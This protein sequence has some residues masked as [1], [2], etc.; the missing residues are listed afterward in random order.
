MPLHILLILVIGGIAAI[1]VLMHVLG[2]SERLI[3][4]TASARAAWLRH[5]PE[6]HVND[7]V[8]ANDGHAALILAQDGPGLLWSFGADTAA[9]PLQGFTFRDGERTQTV[10][11]RDFAAPRV[12][13]HLSEEERREWQSM[14][15]GA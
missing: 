15:K 1:A 6:D 10:R 3:L 5:F 14:M 4:N 13:L 2:K 11:F 8:V 7:V 9:R 12:K